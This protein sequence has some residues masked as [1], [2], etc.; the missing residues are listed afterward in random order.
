MVEIS[1]P[2]AV[3]CN[4]ASKAESGGDLQ[5]LGLAPARRQRAAERGAALVQIF[6]LR[7]ARRQLEEGNLGQFL[8]GQRDLE[9][10]AEAFQRVFA[11]L[12]GLM[13][14]HH[15]FAGLAHAVA[16][17]GLGEND[18][19][20]ALVL[21]RRLVGGVDL[22]RIVAAARQRPDLVVG[23]VL[24]HLGGLGIAAEEILAD[25]G[26]VLRLEVLIFAV[27][28]FH[29]QLAQLA[30]LV[31]GEQ[32]VPAGA[33]QAFDDVPA[34]AAEVGF[35]LLHDLAVAAHRPVEP[36]QIAVDD[37]DEIVE[38]LAARQRDRAERFRLVHLAVAAEHPDLA[39]G[40]VGEAASVQI[41]QEARLIDRHQ[42]AP[43]PSRRSGTARNPASARDAD[44]TTGPC[45]PTSWR[46]LTSCSSL[47]RPSRKARA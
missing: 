8:V 29:H 17:D 46:K 47:S 36:L 38:L 13:G 3:A 35:E 2:S 18:G 5:R 32:R 4:S 15:A 30:V 10:V 43:G 7:A 39:L 37:E 1:R 24:H 41:A 20:L 31:P 44:R 33:P 19:R 16:F 34:G 42:A 27:D 28:A 40:R 26:A 11:D 9:A 12:L 6:L 14:D 22:D 23:P 45:P 21:A 25:I